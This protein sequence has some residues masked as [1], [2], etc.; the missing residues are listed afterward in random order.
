MK[1]YF[2]S[3]AVLDNINRG[4]ENTFLEMYNFY[5]PKIFRHICYRLGSREAAEDTA[6]QVFCKTW[7]YIMDPGHKIDNLNAFLYKIANN[8]IADYYRRPERKN[9]SLDDGLNDDRERKLSV[10]PSYTNIID[11]NLEVGRVKDGLRQLKDDQQELI[12]WR[13]FDDLSISEIAKISGKSRNAIYV[14]IHRATHDLRN[15]IEKI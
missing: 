15:I 12:T 2:K 13:Y 9:I 5:A 14:G 1:D 7:Q 8:L 6:Q 3:A 11:R 10:D 4:D